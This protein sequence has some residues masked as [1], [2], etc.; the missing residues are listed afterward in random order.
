STTPVRHDKQ[1]NDES[2][3][4]LLKGCI[5][6][7]YWTQPRGRVGTLEPPRS[8]RRQPPFPPD[9]GAQSTERKRRAFDFARER[10]ILSIDDLKKR[11]SRERMSNST[12]LGHPIGVQ[13]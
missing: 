8:Q 3:P 7:T 1:P 12:Q 13:F 10:E 5:E 11:Q 2:M 6:G 9:A 4:G